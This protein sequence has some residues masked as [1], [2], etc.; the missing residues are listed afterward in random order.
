MQSQ[1][2]HYIFL[3]HSSADN[4][5]V[6][7]FAELLKSRPLAQQHNIDVWLDKT[8]LVDGK[9]YTGEFAENIHDAKT[10]AFILFVPEQPLSV[11]VKHEVEQGF[12]R[13]MEA[14]KN[15]QDFLIFPVYPG[16]KDARVDLPKLIANF[17]YK[18]HVHENKEQA[19][20][21]LQSVVASLTKQQVD[22]AST[23]TATQPQPALVTSGTPVPPPDNTRPE[24]LS[25]TLE[26]QGSLIHVSTPFGSTRST[27]AEQLQYDPF[28]GYPLAA[29]GH[30]ITGQLQD[31]DSMK[32]FLPS[33]KPVRL[34]LATHEEDLLTLPW[35]RIKDPDNHAFPDNFSIEVSLPVET[36]TPCRHTINKPHNPLLLIPDKADK[37]LKSHLNL[38]Q[39]YLHSELNITGSI[40][41]ATNRY[42]IQQALQ[43]DP[44]DLLYICAPFDGEYLT[45]DPDLRAPNDNGQL[46]LEE[47]GGW[48]KQDSPPI[49]ILHLLG[50]PVD[51]APKKLIQKSRFVWLLRDQRLTSMANSLYDFL[52]HVANTADITHFINTQSL[53][54]QESITHCLWLNGDTP[55][56]DLDPTVQQDLHYQQ[57]RVAL[58]RVVLGRQSLKNDLFTEIAHSRNFNTATSQAL[59]F[60][61]SGEQEACPS[62]F[63]AQL[64]QRIQWDDPENALPV[65]S[66]DLSLNLLASTDFHDVRDSILQT[67]DDHLRLGH[68][69][70]EEQFADRKPVHGQNACLM[71]NWFLTIPENTSLQAFQFWIR[72]WFTVLKQ[73]FIHAIPDQTVLTACLCIEAQTAEQAQN[74]MDAA[75]DTLYQE[76]TPQLRYF[77]IDEALDRLKAPEIRKFL[78]PNGRWYSA[79]K[80]NEHSINPR[81]YAN[82]L[83]QQHN[84]SFEET[85]TTLWQ[86]YQRNHQDFRAHD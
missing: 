34:R 8:N 46:T 18:T 15:Q 7:K 12:Q 75:N 61:V 52:E 55:Y 79:L 82:W 65:T 13:H 78:E 3:S 44:P 53:K 47:L 57:L 35:Q 63:P 66:Y 19:D 74:W 33:D 67:V 81:Q 48:I 17:N 11:W 22:T 36:G 70:L 21:I 77:E 1:T 38:I 9:P 54:L 37:Q 42:S 60:V 58:L 27:D 85:V 72:V 40:T 84:G 62:V 51:N 41:R 32:R 14:Q 2:S 26:K 43:V 24:W 4:A 39:Q 64:R 69:T 59:C 83:H 49:V 6:I 68:D 45:L 29:M 10:C 56:F 28:S 31:W 5:E 20:S 23:Q 16:P 80:L 86:Q 30:L 25:Y 76:S 71:L 73:E 50:K